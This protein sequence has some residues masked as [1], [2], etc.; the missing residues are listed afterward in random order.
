[1]L[2]LL[3]CRAV[4]AA[5]VIASAC[6][7]AMPV[8]AEESFDGVLLRGGGSSFAAPLFNGWIEA[9]AKDQ[10]SLAVEYDSVGSGEGMSRLVTGALDFAGTDA[11]LP[12]EQ[13]A[14]VEGQVLYL[15]LAAGLVAICYNL[16]GFRGEL[17]LPR[18]AYAGIFDGTITK[19]D[20]A[21]IAA[22]NPNLQLPQRTIAVVVRRD[23][24]GTTFAFTN[25]LNAIDLH[26]Q[27]RK[28]G[29]ALRIDWPAGAMTA[30]GN[31]GV[32]ATILQA[33]YSIGYV[34]YGFA[35]RLDLPMAVLENR[36]GQFVAPAV[37]AGEAVLAPEMAA[38]RTN[39]VRFVSD[40]AGASSYPI[41][42]LT[43]A[44]VHKAYSDPRK[45][46]ALKVFLGWGLVEG[47]PVAKGLEYVTL[48]TALVRAAQAALSE[49]H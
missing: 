10:P 29:A 33:E 4:V 13:A 26:W 34:E 15:P 30:R 49:V 21:R 1:M 37:P 36:Q 47:Q 16:P 48:P 45:A 46:D 25:H 5:A 42:T 14:M 43:W 39:L 27:E 31:E 3:T 20:D 40:P 44:L 28:L 2:G 18:E 7:A 8:V 9:F 32:A 38:H 35:Q 24:S 12:A 11:P 41:V 6:G 22:A 23:G 17:R 19:W